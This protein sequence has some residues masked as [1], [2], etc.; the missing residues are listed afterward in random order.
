ME[1]VDAILA[2]Q[3]PAKE[4]AKRVVE[5]IKK[6]H[7]DASGVLYLEGQKT[8]MIEDND[9]AAPFRQRRYFYYLTGCDLPDAY[10]TYDI[11]SGKSTLFI[12]PIDAE[13]VIWSGLPVSPSEALE[14]Y[15]VDHV[16]TA[17]TVASYLAKPS[18]GTVYAINNQVSDHITFLQFA[19]TDLMLLKEAI[20]ECRVIKDA[21]EI[22]L[23]KKANLISTIAH[24]AV[25]K[26]VKHAKNER[27][28]EGVFIEKC[29]ANEAREQAYHSIVASGT[30]A[31]TLHYQKNYQ[32]LEGKLNLLLDAGGEYKM[33]ASDITRTFPISGRFSTES[34]LL[35]DI[36]MKMQVDTI[37]MLKA[38]V[39]WDD[40]HLTAHKIAIDCLLALGILSGD[41]NEILKARTSVAFFPHGLGH[42]LGMDTHDTG[43]HPDYEDKDTMFR[44]LRVRGKL[45]AGSIITVEPGIYFCRF[46]IEPYLK[47]PAH[48]KFINVDVLDKYWEVGGVRI[49]DN[50][51]ITDDGHENLTT[52]VKD[53]DEMLA[54][55]NST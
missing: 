54:L 1:A 48:S 42:Y 37:A 9:E 43:G 32:N 26:A 27:E 5:Y 49:E 15:D 46:I 50:V 12:P 33:Y 7:P 20:E 22:G 34:R 35:Y 38:G 17:D 18:Q 51:L 47:D 53:V 30:A 21:Y 10:F 11:A 23:I 41:K 6:T 3:Y 55:I 16:Q 8:C 52:A 25:L 44:Y 29:I 40:V 2:G 14:L 4:H 31:A 24:T 39:V 28:L 45:P 36:V 13:S 19:S